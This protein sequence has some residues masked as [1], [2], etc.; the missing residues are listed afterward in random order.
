M[1]DATCCT[2]YADGGEKQCALRWLMENAPESAEAAIWTAIAAL[3]WP[4]L[5]GIVKALKFCKW[6]GAICC[7]ACLHN[8]SML[9]SPVHCH[10]L[11]TQKLKDVSPCLCDAQLVGPRLTTISLHRSK[12]HLLEAL[13]AIACLLKFPSALCDPPLRFSQ[14]VAFPH[15]HHGVAATAGSWCLTQRS[16]AAWRS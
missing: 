16:A 7:L 8:S 6:V 13:L 10:L 4:H 2:C 12:M 14:L 11:Q 1:K 9:P 15:S 5:D 3:S